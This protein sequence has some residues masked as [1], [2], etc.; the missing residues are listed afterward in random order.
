VL[1]EPP[2]ADPEGRTPCPRCG[3]LTRHFDQAV[4]GTVTAHGALKGKARRTIGGKP[5]LE[6]QTG[7]D[8]HPDTGAW[9]KLYRLIDRKND[10]YVEQII[11][12]DGSAERVDEL[13]T[14]HRG[15]G[16]DKSSPTTHP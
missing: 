10:R 5:W 4:G 7:D 15:H 6:F 9:S 3:S 11:A 8:L 1:D 12:E 14:E 13:L 2:E 16:A